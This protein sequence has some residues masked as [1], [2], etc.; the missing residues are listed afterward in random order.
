MSKAERHK[1][2][3]DEYE[4]QGGSRRTRNAVDRAAAQ[5]AQRRQSI[6]AELR[7]GR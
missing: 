3:G 5:E 7:R 1:K 2:S 6:E 4:R